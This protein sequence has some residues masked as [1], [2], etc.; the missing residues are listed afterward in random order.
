M[1]QLPTCLNS[2]SL[3]SLIVLT[4]VTPALQ[5]GWCLCLDSSC[6][7]APPS[8]GHFL[9]SGVYVQILHKPPSLL[10]CFGWGVSLWCV[11]EGECPG[12]PHLHSAEFTLVAV[13][14]PRTLYLPLQPHVHICAHTHMRAPIDTWKQ[15][16]STT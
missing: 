4:N 9:S 16:I 7:G 13:P 8:P 11:G 3:L 1:L 15:K 10:G 2:S 6:S 5:R 12:T 14:A